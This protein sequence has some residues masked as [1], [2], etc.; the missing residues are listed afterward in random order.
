[1][2]LGTAITDATP[3]TWSASSA[4]SC[5]TRSSCWSLGGCTD[6]CVFQEGVA[7]GQYDGVEL[8]IG[9]AARTIRNVRTPDENR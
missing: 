5:G 8:F 2:K 4:G 1:M 3:A 6:R 7:E 9:K